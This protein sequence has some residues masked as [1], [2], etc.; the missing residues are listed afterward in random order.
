[1]G[2]DRPQ[3]E[4]GVQTSARRAPEEKPRCHAGLLT[5]GECVPSRPCHS[6]QEGGGGFEGNAVGRDNEAC[7]Q[8]GTERWPGKSALGPGGGRPLPSPQR[9]L[10]VFPRQPPR[11]LGPGWAR[12]QLLQ[13]SPGAPQSMSWD[14]TWLSCSKAWALTP[15]IQPAPQG[16]SPEHG[17]LRMGRGPGW[18]DQHP[19]PAPH[20][21]QSSVPAAGPRAP[22]AAFLPLADPTLTLAGSASP[23]SLVS[24]FISTIAPDDLPLMLVF[25]CEGP[26]WAARP[27]SYR[28]AC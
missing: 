20:F 13:G 1:M 3:S 22:D 2:Q 18:L 23:L 15:L 27:R 7:G 24:S 6:L 11:W 5:C 4:S 25:M 19:S 12:K 26:W 10:L 17:P 8:R 28:G 16:T 21:Q 14:L 9:P